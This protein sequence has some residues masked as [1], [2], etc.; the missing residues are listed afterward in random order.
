MLRKL[1][2][3]F[4]HIYVKAKMFIVIQPFGFIHQMLMDKLLCKNDWILNSE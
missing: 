2:V 1:I 3:Q 4:K